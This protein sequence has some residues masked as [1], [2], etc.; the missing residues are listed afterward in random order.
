MA[1]SIVHFLIGQEYFIPQ[2]ALREWRP[3][4]TGRLLHDRGCCDVRL[5]ERKATSSVNNKSLFSI[6]KFTGQHQLDDLAMADQT[7]HVK[8][9]VLEA[10]K[11]FTTCD[12]HLPAT[13]K[14]QP[15]I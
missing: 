1:M 5:E 8:Q 12:V 6:L 13:P 3:R 14:P 4:T 9:P 2:H 7:H 11:H 10:L 15:I